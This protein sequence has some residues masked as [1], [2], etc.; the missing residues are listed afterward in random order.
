MCIRDS[1]SSDCLFGA[2]DI[3]G[4]FMVLAT[5]LKT[6]FFTTVF[7]AIPIS[8]IGAAK[9]L[10]KVML[11]MGRI[12]TRSTGCKK[13]KSSKLNEAVKENDEIE[14]RLGLVNMSFQV[15][16]AISR[17]A[18]VDRTKI[19]EYLAKKFPDAFA[20][21]VGKLKNFQFKL[22]FNCDPNSV[23]VDN[24]RCNMYSKKSLQEVEHIIEKWLADGIIVRAGNVPQ[25]SNI[26]I[27]P[28]KKIGQEKPNYGCALTIRN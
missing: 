18:K 21:R 19:Q 24:K 7:P 12:L 1:L 23:L 14:Y 25:Y 20:D 13:L 22:E 27:V 6:V 8:M 15:I 10:E 26:V 3:N 5:R 16:S 4:E 28:K 9:D 17:Q 2:Q 11:E